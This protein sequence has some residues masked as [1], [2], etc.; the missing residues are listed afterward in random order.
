MRKLTLLSLLLL[1][2][3]AMAQNQESTDKEQGEDLQ[4][5]I[6]NPI[7]NLISLPFQNNIDFGV[8]PDE[9]TKNTLNI[10]PVIPLSINEDL[11]LI[12]RTIVP[13]I[14]QPLGADDSEFGLGDTTI[15]LWL[16][17]AAPKKVILGYGV[18]LG[19]PTATDPTL[20][21]GKWSAGPSLVALIQPG[22]WT[23][24]GLTQQTWSYAGQSDRGD[25]S[26]L[27]SQLFVTR[28]LSN[29]WYVNSAPI[30]IANWE[31]ASG[32]QWTVPIG[33][34]GGKLIKTGGIPL[35]VQLGYYYNVVRPDFGPESQ[36]RIQVTLLF[37]K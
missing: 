17:S 16:T 8:G 29:G 24:G 31:A 20:G 26:L 32:N 4:K 1:G 35:N 15:A 18:A 30:I 9:R 5:A 3:V 7:A 10:Q 12:T 6:Q 23:I 27:F 22:D 36:F 37:P 25:V 2:T 28:N 19:I 11:N 14:S 34:G 13:V 21:S 33:A